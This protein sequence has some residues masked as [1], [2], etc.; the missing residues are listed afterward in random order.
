M[1]KRQ[2]SQSRG[3]LDESSGD[4]LADTA[5]LYN[6]PRELACFPS[7]HNVEVLA[8]EDTIRPKSSR[9]TKTIE[10]DTD[11]P[12]PPIP[13]KDPSEEQKQYQ[14]PRPALT[15]KTTNMK[16]TNP[17][18]KQGMIPQISPP[19]L[20]ETTNSSIT[21]PDLSRSTTSHNTQSTFTP[22]TS[23][24]GAADLSRKIST[25]ME[26]AAAQE[27][28]THSK[29]DAYIAASI[30][31]SPLER[32]K[33][34]F[35]KATRAIKERLNNGNTDRPPKPERPL[36]KRHSS[37]QDSGSL[38][39]PPTVWQYEI[40]NGLS[41]E[42]LDRRIAEGENLSNPKIR[43]L[44]GDGSI[45]RKPVPVYESM[46]SRS[47]RSSSAD[48]PFSDG[49]EG[50][51]TQ[52]PQGYSGF[53]FDFNKHKQRDKRTSSADDTVE[54]AAEGHNRIDE[55]PERSNQLSFA[56]LST[57][58]LSNII[59]GLAQHSETMY[60]SSSPLGHST[61][62][63]RFEPQINDDADSQT[64]RFL[65]RTPSLPASKSED[66]DGDVLMRDW[67]PQ[68]DPARFSNGS[69][70]SVKRKEAT[71]DLR[72]QSA[73]V[74]KKA[75]TD[76]DGTKED[77]G[78][79]ARINN[80]D[81]KDERVPLSPT[82]VNTRAGYPPRNGSKRKGVR[83]FDV[84]KGKEKESKDNGGQT[85]K[86]HN[87][88][89]TTKRS[90]LTRP[91]NALFSRRRNSRTGMHQHTHSDEDSMD[92]DELQMHNAAYLVGNKKR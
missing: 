50:S 74:A 43:S 60:F 48:D 37:F 69:S 81:T 83:I 59:S 53:N 21:V 14:K 6:V 1:T 82:S 86:T 92:I 23:I 27:E 24:A 57:S 20:Q 88:L 64:R 45:A 7:S 35:V 73:P 79:V 61:P 78:L 54:V 36:A 41:R 22:Q 17:K 26:Q 58:R 70:L 56:P 30:K 4:E 18:A 62:R 49:K 85:S 55:S 16:V 9:S 8:I 29:T 32:G 77:L 33:H 84:G 11:K 75:K 71:K 63:T 76:P 3:R 65:S 40:L 19:V 47:M 66:L 87:G 51:N 34:A 39:P 80:L 38:G 90:S 5:I 72:A 44:T 25:L 67:S 46:R 68:S 31:A 15:G 28:Q 42:R 12:L 52:P 2:R 91:G 10:D 89:Q 13:T